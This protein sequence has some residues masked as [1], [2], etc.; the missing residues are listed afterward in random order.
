MIY[1][2]KEFASNCLNLTQEESCPMS[3]TDRT[4]LL[5]F[6]ANLAVIVNS[7]RFE[8]S[9]PVFRQRVSHLTTLSST[10]KWLLK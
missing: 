1:Y 6:P 8:L 2:P 9:Q 7:L 3:R 4:P 10:L 5:S